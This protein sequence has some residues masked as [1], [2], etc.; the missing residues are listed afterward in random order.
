[1]FL[2]AIEYNLSNLE[3]WAASA[4]SEKAHI[5]VVAELFLCGYNIR[6][7]DRESASVYVEEA[8]SMVT[9]IAIEKKIALIV[10]YAERV[11][12]SDQMFDS[13]ILVDKEGNLLKNYRKCQLWGS[14]ERTVWKYP[15]TD[16]PDDVR[17]GKP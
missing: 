6:P 14:D 15:Y 11:E 5:L 9:P 2:H 8:V 3:K 4:A 17:Y 10:P 12:G 1:L 13:M 7:E 16:S